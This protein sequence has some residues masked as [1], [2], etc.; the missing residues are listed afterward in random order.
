MAYTLGD[1]C[2]KNLCE[3]II[4][5]Q[6]IVENVVTCFFWN[7]VYK[8]IAIYTVS[9]EK[10]ERYDYYDITSPIHDVYYLF[11]AHTLFNSQFNKLIFFLNWLK[12]N[13][14]VTI[15]TVAT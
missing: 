13:C 15:A 6:L 10:P 3:R 7:T 8:K 9:Q 1:K 11:L 4:L 5:L 2:A 12:T 14:V